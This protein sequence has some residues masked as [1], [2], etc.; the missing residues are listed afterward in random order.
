MALVYVL[1]WARI[2]IH[3]DAHGNVYALLVLFFFTTVPNLIIWAELDYD[4]IVFKTTRQ[5]F[6]SDIIFNGF[7]S[8]LSMSIL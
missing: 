2:L 3:A 7:L 8:L 1:V 4:V 6:V 5:T